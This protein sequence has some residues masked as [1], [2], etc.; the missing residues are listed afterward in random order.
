MP[1]TTVSLYSLVDLFHFMEAGRIVV[2]KFQRGY[3]WSKRDA[4]MLFDS[5]NRGLPIG[6]L[7]T[8]ESGTERFTE[9]LSDVS[10]FPKR[11]SMAINS[12]RRLWL[13]DGVQRLA[14]LYNG[15]FESAF[16]LGILYDLRSHKFVF[17]DQVD[18]NDALLPMSSLFHTGRLMKLQ[19]QLV[20]QG[21]TDDL[22]EDLNGIR[23]RF[24]TYQVPT[25]VV[26][27]TA[28][29]DLIEVFTRLN[30]IGTPLTR[31]E[32]ERIS[33]EKPDEK[34]EE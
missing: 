2:P 19:A 13:I 18:R 16:S 23:E 21:S 17:Q 29:E 27:D 11:K 8:V 5:V 4:V 20:K 3:V 22:I 15:L 31:E 33:E 14:T 26:M 1:K 12:T 7:I 24:Y 10:T 32:L 25:M 6:M 9:A 30:S 34:K 28:P